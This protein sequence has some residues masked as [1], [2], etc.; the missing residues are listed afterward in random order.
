[1][2][3]AFVYRVNRCE[4][5]IA[6]L[7]TTFVPRNDALCQW[8]GIEVYD[9]A[10]RCLSPAR[11]GSSLRDERKRGVAIF[12]EKAMSNCKLTWQLSVFPV[13]PRRASIRTLIGVY[14][15]GAL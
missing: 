10:I 15:P 5:E 8:G 9:V 14:L 13:Y 3:W 1:M 4:H 12:H 11:Q 2:L 6:A 7:L